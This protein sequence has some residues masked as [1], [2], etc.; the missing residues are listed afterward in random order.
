MIDEG[1]VRMEVCEEWGTHPTI[2]DRATGFVAANLVNKGNSSR[3]HH[4]FFDL[5]F[6]DRAITAVEVPVKALL[7]RS[8]M[9]EISCTI[10]SLSNP[11]TKPIASAPGVLAVTSSEVPPNC[12]VIHLF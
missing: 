11:R 6:F 12:R 5:V 7:T 10:L 1:N 4:G 2:S 3:R 8:S 9:G